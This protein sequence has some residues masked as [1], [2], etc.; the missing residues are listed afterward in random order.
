MFKG[1]LWLIPEGIAYFS[2][3][4]LRGWVG[5]FRTDSVDYGS[6]LHGIIKPLPAIVIVARGLQRKPVEVMEGISGIW[7][8]NVRGVRKCYSACTGVSPLIAYDARMGLNFI[9]MNMCDDNA[10]LPGKSTLHPL[11]ILRH[12]KHAA[13]KLKPRNSSRLHVAFIDFSQAYDTVLRQQLWSHLQRN[14]MPT[15]LLSHAPL[16][17]PE[18][19][20]Y[21]CVDA[22]LSLR[23]MSM[24]LWCVGWWWR[25]RRQHAPLRQPKAVWYTCVGAK[26]EAAEV[27]KVNPKWTP[28]WRQDSATAEDA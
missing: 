23:D 7:K 27:C 26:Q 17:Q 2:V 21:T 22:K 28:Q 12:L 11:F 18:A 24:L 3:G 9:E 14:A 4:K 10:L 13:K 6:G 1:D 20:W 16:R 19:V 8:C 25:W 15:P 5:S